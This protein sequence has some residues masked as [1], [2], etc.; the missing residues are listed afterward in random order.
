MAQSEKTEVVRDELGRIVSG[1]LNPSGRP[2]SR[3]KEAL[4]KA[5]TDDD[6]VAI[7]NKAVQ[8]ARAGDRYAR[9]WLGNYIEG[10]P[11][12]AQ[13]SEGSDSAIA[14]F[15]AM[16][17]E[18]MKAQRSKPDVEAEYTVEDVDL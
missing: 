5:V 15:E 3:L 10:K 14:F 16:R 7:V 12:N 6:L 4:A 2:K 8:D 1:S 11:A 17:K 18:W 9:E 13:P